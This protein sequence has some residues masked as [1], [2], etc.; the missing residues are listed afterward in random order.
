MPGISVANPRS[1]GRT[2]SSSTISESPG[3][4]PRTAIGPVAELTR[5]KSIAV[6]RS[7]SLWIWPVKQSFVS[8]VIMEP[9]STSSTGSMFGPNAQTTSSRPMRWEVVVAIS[10]PPPGACRARP[11]PDT[12]SST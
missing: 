4:A 10:G 6:T 7:A 3:S 5:W 2:S 8:R 1:A 12:S 11:R 9:G